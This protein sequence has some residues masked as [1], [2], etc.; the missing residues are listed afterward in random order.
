MFV[1]TKYDESMK[2]II[3][4]SLLSL[5]LFFKAQTN[6]QPSLEKLK[7]KELDVKRKSGFSDTK[8]SSLNTNNVSSIISIIPNQ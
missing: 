5:P 4:I 3:L 6:K 2:K 1:N 7:Q 8:S